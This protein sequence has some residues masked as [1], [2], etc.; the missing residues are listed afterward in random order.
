MPSATDIITRALRLL[1]VTGATDTPEAEELAVGKIALDDFVDSLG[2]ERASIFTVGRNVYPLSNGVASY[3]IGTGGTFNQIRPVWI[4]NASVIPD[5][6]ATPA[7]EIPI[8]RPINIAEWQ[9]ITDKSSTAPWPTACYYD[10]AWSAGLGNLSVYPVPNTGLASLVLY[11]PSAATAFADLTTVYALPPGWS[12]MYRYNL[13]MELADDFG[14]NPSSRV[15]RI[16]I[17]ALAAV[18]RANVRPTD[19]TLDPL[20]PGLRGSGRFDLYTGS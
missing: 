12:R 6:T 11:T 7:L 15:E 16:A 19:A 5:R 9:G 20:M 4:D 17:Q 2:L 3:T 18:K 14:K 1:G 8:G 13:A 10:F